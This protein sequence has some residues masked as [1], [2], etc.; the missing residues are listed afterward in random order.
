MPKSVL[1]TPRQQDLV[2]VDRG[3]LSIIERY[4]FVE[5]RLA[6]QP[7]DALRRR[8]RSRREQLAVEHK[9]F[10][11]RLES[12]DLLPHAP[13]TDLED[14]KRIAAAVRAWVENDTRQ[15]LLDWLI[16]TEQNWQAVLEGFESSEIESATIKPLHESAASAIDGMKEFRS[17][18]GE[19]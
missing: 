17:S 19:H 12:E 18:D 3:L 15:A 4:R 11:Q 8:I 10:K 1:L 7:T 9:E 16:E 6:E 13:E 2:E 14:L 5:E